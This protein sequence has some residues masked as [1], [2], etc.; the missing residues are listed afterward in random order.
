MGECMI[1]RWKHQNLLIGDD[2]TQWVNDKRCLLVMVERNLSQ[3]DVV[4]PS[5]LL[6]FDFNSH[7]SECNVTIRDQGSSEDDND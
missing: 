4:Y 5:D 7:I 6:R 2:D 1:K 3:P